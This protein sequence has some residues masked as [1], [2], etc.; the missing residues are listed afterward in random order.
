MLDKIA[1]GLG[2][3]ALVG[4]VGSAVSGAYGVVSKTGQALGAAGKALTSAG[5]A[6]QNTSNPSSN[7]ITGKFG[8][9]GTAGRQKV[10]GGGILPAPKAIVKPQVSSKMPTEALLDTAV[11]YL[12]SI[13][14]SLKSQ[15]EFER[16]S[17]QEQAQVERESIIE[18]KSATTFSDIK[19]RLSGFKSNVKDSAGTAATIAKFALILGGAASL[20]AAALDQKEFDALKQNV[21]EF[22]NKFSWLGDMA[23]FI[24]LGGLAG[25]IFG[26][27]GGRLKGGLIGI[28]ASHVISRLY[29][30]FSGGEYKT[31]ADGNVLIDQNGE[32]IKE[33]RSMSA[34]GYGLSAAAGIIAA[35]SIAKRLPAAKLAAQSAGQLSRAAGSSS[36]AGVQAAT[37]KG[38]SW[39][40]SRRGRKFLVILGRKLGKGLMAKVGKYLARIVAGLLLTATGIG[41]IPGILVI[42][43]S[44]AFIGFDIFDVATS[45]YDAFNESAAEDTAAMAVPAGT[46]EQDATNVSASAVGYSTTRA[47]S[48]QNKT[49]TGVVDGGPGYTTVT[50]SDGT[51]ERRGG[52]LPARTNN[53]GNIM[54][55]D[56]AKSYGAV[57][58][59]PSTNGPPVAVFPTPTHGFA[60]MDG[61]LTS[62]YSNGPIG[63]TIEAWATDPSH[64]AKVLG[65]SGLDPNKKYTDFTKDEKVR[66]MQ[67]L[68]KVEGYYAAGS[69]PSVS[70]G[71]SASASSGIGG[72]MNAGAEK[73]GQIFGMLGSS[74]I[75]PGVE[76]KFAP[77]GGNVSEQINN[78]S[79]KLQNDITFG[80]KKEKAKD[81]ITSP[82]IS[83]GKARGASP[84][85][86]VSSIDPNYQNMDVLTK[87]LSHFR[88]AA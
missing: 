72:M 47:T 33:S 87:Y 39:L 68:A 5:T 52:T 60:A 16:R 74:I 66:F 42:L 14:K 10:T 62:K 13:D 8:M 15:V 61:L 71:G 7:V 55:G 82:T 80:I 85:K 35:R 20:V 63:Q 75:K 27:K 2:A 40:A 48:G 21:E 78:Q 73:M 51:T 44:I 77:S 26:G 70:S 34:A 57:G 12:V 86:S 9:A 29:S 36:I 11:K 28:V 45:I 17:Y 54:Y 43:G 84:V 3:K 59:S 65:S 32:P 76:K 30:S 18:T 6:S 1:V 56:I 81:T 58:S 67:S 46:K 31:D 23:S 22:K 25:F 53:P 50:Y 69:G 24:G 83:A 88:L 79:M 64:P 38:T 37:R 19:D 4:A 49:I 41:A